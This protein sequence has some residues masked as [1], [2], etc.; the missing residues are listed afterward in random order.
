MFYKTLLNDLFFIIHPDHSTMSQ[1][2]VAARE[3]VFEVVDKFALKPYADMQ[4]QI[5][6]VMLPRNSILSR[7]TIK[8]LDKTVRIHTMIHNSD[9]NLRI[10]MLLSPR[11]YN[12]YILIRLSSCQC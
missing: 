7:I 5:L 6:V 11:G 12:D 10:Q 1:M 4:I 2:R 8:G 3:Y 9:F